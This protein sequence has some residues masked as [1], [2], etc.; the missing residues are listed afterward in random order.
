MVLSA[1]RVEVPLNDIHDIYENTIMDKPRKLSQFKKIRSLL[2]F[3]ASSNVAKCSFHYFRDGIIYKVVVIFC[4]ARL[5]K[6]N[7]IVSKRFVKFSNVY[8]SNMPVFF[9]EKI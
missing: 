3:L 6:T 5:F 8:I 7:N 1:L 9:V 2:T 4:W